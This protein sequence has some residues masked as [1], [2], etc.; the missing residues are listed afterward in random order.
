MKYFKTPKRS[1][2]Q[3]DAEAAAT[4]IAAASDIAL[5]IDGDGIICDLALNN[6]EIA[7]RISGFQSWIGRRWSQT[8]T[9]DSVQKIES[10]LRE[11]GAKTI[12]DWRQV[13]HTAV[14]GSDIPILYSTI[15]AGP[16]RI[17]AVGRDL[18]PIA[19]MQQRLVEAQNAMERDYSRLRQVEMRYRLLF[20]FSAEAL[21]VVESNGHRVVDSN[22]AAELLLAGPNRRAGTWS[23]REVFDKTAAVPLDA[24]FASVRAAGRADDVVTRLA[25]SGREVRV[26]ASLLRQEAGTFLLVR[27]APTDVVS[28]TAPLPKLKAKLLKVVENAPDGVVLT[29]HDGLV[30]AANAAFLELAHLPGE[31]QARGQSLDRWVGRPGVDI[32]VLVGNLR[33]HGSIRL[34]RTNLRAEF[35]PP[36]EVEISAVSVMNGGN[37]CFGFT[38]RNVSRRL[39]TD[40]V[41]GRELP[42]SVE[43]LKELVGRVA[44]KDLVRDTT[45]MIER[46]Y[47][48]SALELTGDNRASAAEMLGLSRQSLYV[49]LRRY[50]LAELSPSGGQGQG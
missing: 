50:G 41:G 11:A 42:R 10:L 4:L 22:P 45:D 28:A 16:G 8:V 6:D 13:N 7:G 14:E 48:E 27:I 38:I 19:A 30:L 26:S 47:I 34:F 20:E 17:V 2:G 15:L 23:L 31:E 39:A 35:G 44:L 12:S 43:Q 49:K 37:A 1:L 3:L 21:V 33:R 36:A 46:L 9:P 25:N 24:L 29:D 18:R 32:E 5:I 40:G